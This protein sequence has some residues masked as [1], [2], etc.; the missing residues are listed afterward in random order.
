M[1]GYVEELRALV[2]RRPLILPRTHVYVLDGSDRLLL[3]RRT[4]T[5]GWGLP[6]GFMEPGETLE[7]TARRETLEKTGLTVGDLSLLRVFSGPDCHVHYP[8]G[9]EV[10]SV[11]AAYLTRDFEGALKRD[12]QEATAL[13]F[14]DLRDEPVQA[15][16][17]TWSIVAECIRLIA[18]PEHAGDAR[19]C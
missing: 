15:L 9:D 5:G 19:V 18:S 17:A 2:R 12:S 1:P 11:T 10:Y 14:F 3:M 16:G 6:G 8:N 13:A 4:D 7:E